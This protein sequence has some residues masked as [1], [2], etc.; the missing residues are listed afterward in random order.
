[1]TQKAD[2]LTLMENDIDSGPKEAVESHGVVRIDLYANSSNHSWDQATDH[3][4]ILDNLFFISDHLFF[5]F[6]FKN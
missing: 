5:K 1:M 3:G 2:E 6:I 4:I